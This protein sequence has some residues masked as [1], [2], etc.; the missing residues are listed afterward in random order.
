MAKELQFYGLPSTQSGL[1]ITISLFNTEGVEVSSNII[2]TEVNNTAIYI[3]DMPQLPA[4]NYVVRFYNSGSYLIQGY[5]DW[6]GSKE[7]DNS[8]DFT[9][10]EK[11]YLFNRV[12]ELY[13]IHGLDPDNPLYV[14]L[15]QRI[16]GNIS[17]SINYNNSED[18]TIITRN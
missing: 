1:S 15:T 18:K 14:D 17:Q 5:I 12:N 7:I 10:D 16:A 9:N 2:A 6:D 4:D 3:A 11:Q 8:K 13:L